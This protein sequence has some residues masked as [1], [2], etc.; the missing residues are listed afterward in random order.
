[1]LVSPQ[2]ADTRHASVL[3]VD[4]VK[5]G[6]VDA[7]R[8]ALGKIAHGHRTR[9]AGKLVAVTGSAGKTT[10]KEMIRGALGA[11]GA[12][13]AADGSLNNET[14]V[15]LTLLGLRPFHV[16]GVV[17]MGMRGANQIEHL[18]RIAEP[19]VAV[20]INA[21]SAHIELLGSTDA[22][23]AA[24]SEIWLGLRPGGTVV[25]PA[26]DDRL[27]RH[28]R[29]HQ[30]R[31]RHVTFGDGAADVRLVDYAPSAG[32][33]AIVLDVFGARHELALAL[34]GRHAAIDACAAI[35][36]SHAAGASIEEVLVGI[37]RVRPPALRGEIVDV[38]GR[39][40]I[41][42]CYNAN[43]ASMAA[44]LRTLAERGNGRALAVLGDML[45]LGDHAAVAHRE[46]G[47][48][49]RELGIGVIALGGQAK[50]VVE[51]AGD[52]AEVADSPELA[53]ARTLARS[54][55]G[56]WILLKAS[57]GMKLERV[58]EAMRGGR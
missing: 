54:E 28:A 36:A 25:R 15:P 6:I 18:A 5:P 35:A 16:Y 21:G 26:G 40:V 14:G 42:D 44:A 45:E 24:K 11:A 8:F 46:A 33:S 38:D 19:D 37:A 29:A 43:P 34:V 53:A 1:T 12:T 55:P 13:H 20:V 41:V 57:R 48:L 49:A 4:Q 3:V 50:L 17:E 30:P 51:A 27:E 22:I 31:A 32:G 2:Y 58:L 7:T 23:A 10:T 47:A 9:W 56:D 52:H 39:H